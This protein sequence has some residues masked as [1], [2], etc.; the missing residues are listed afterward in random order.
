MNDEERLHKF[1]AVLNR[2]P[3]LLTFKE[4]YVW[5][6]GNVSLER[7]IECLVF[8]VWSV[9]S[10]IPRAYHLCNRGGDL[11]AYRHVNGSDAEIIPIE[12]LDGWLLAAFYNFSAQNMYGKVIALSGLQTRMEH[13]LSEILDYF[14]PGNDVPIERASIKRESIEYILRKHNLQSLL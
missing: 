3:Y 10:I 5:L 8:K 1:T 14:R 4:N 6:A 13:A 7:Q 11:R 9:D 2:F 12:E